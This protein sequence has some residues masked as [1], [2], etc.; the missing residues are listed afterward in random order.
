MAVRQVFEGIKVL[1]MSWV[2]VGPYTMR[3]LADHGAEVIRVESIT[4]TD[5]LRS[6]A[7]FKDGPGINRSQFAGNF[8]SN[9]L[10]LGMNLGNLAR[11]S[12]AAGADFALSATAFFTLCSMIWDTG[13]TM[14]RP[15]LPRTGA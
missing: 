3:Y 14:H 7:P 13:F 8:N 5:V 2:V 4:R 6:G 12:D 10:G 15:V 9:K 11:L 1:D